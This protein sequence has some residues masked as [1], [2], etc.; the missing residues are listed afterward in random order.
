[1]IRGLILVLTQHTAMVVTQDYITHMTHSGGSSANRIQDLHNLLTQHLVLT[2]HNIAS[3]YII[4][5]NIIHAY[6]QYT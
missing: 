2:V 3:S 4:V 6:I 5:K 1:M